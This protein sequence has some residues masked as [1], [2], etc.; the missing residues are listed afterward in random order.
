[1]KSKNLN[2]KINKE[3]LLNIYKKYCKELQLL[4][5]KIREKYLEI[6]K[7][8]RATFSDFE[9]EILY[10][11]I[12][13]RKPETFYEISPDCGYSSIYISSA[14]K[15]NNFGKIYSFEIEATK[16]KISTKKLIM[17]NLQG[18]E[19]KNHEI[20][21]GDVTETYLKKPLPD[22]VLI[23]SCHEGWFAKWYK[24]EIIPIVKD[25][26]FIQDITF[27]DRPEYSGESE[28]MLKF[29]KNKN[30][31]SLGVLEREES[32]R[33][34]NNLFP[35]R[36]SFESNS[37]L[38]KKRKIDNIKA[39]S[40]DIIKNNFF[41]LSIDDKTFYTIENII[42]SYPL[43]QNVHRSYLRLA[44]IKK[45]K[46]LIQK[47][48]GFSIQQ[49]FFTQKPFIETQIFLIRNK[50]FLFFLRTFFY[51]PLITIKTFKIIFELLRIRILKK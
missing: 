37:I 20:I 28:E 9:G 29:L 10:C 3:Y 32:F 30:Y 35:R 17:N 18:F 6:I 31:I 24:K 33:K 11:L 27:Y 2:Y 49:I 7:K 44:L 38:L 42:E 13:D 36:R 1:M 21:I 40:K 26:I 50:F 51:S 46:Y 34:I 45:N 39:N 48:I 43:R 12:R 15:R 41:D 4:T 25:L 5:P 19:Y 14:F 22:M 16:F 47:A 23:D 8:H